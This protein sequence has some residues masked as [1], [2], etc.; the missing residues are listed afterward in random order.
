[1]RPKKQSNA[2]SDDVIIAIG[3]IWGHLS[4]RQF[5]DA[6]YLAQG[7]LSMWPDEK[8]IKLML[9]YAAVELAE[10]IDEDTLAILNNEPCEGWSA[11]VLTR[12][13]SNYPEESDDE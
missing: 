13:D 4:T 6:Y 2:V 7:C 11:L 3:L 10:P 1:M 9:A 8:R 5:E 12:A